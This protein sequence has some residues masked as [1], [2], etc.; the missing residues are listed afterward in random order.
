M[1]IPATPE[2]VKN[3]LEDAGLAFVNMINLN[4]S[5]E[6]SLIPHDPIKYPLLKPHECKPYTNIYPF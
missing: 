5:R 6:R 4:L 3:F 1:K 2:S